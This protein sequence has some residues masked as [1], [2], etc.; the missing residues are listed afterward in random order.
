[1]EK[2]NRLMFI[3]VVL[4]CLAAPFVLSCIAGT[5]TAKDVQTEEQFWAAIK[6]N[7]PNSMFFV[8]YDKESGEPVEVIPS[9]GT[10]TIWNEPITK[11]EHLVEVLD[12]INQEFEKR[13][14]KK[15]KFLD[16]IQETS[17]YVH[18]S[19]GCRTKKTASGRTRV[20]CD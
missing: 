9:P 2:K 15:E 19:P 11:P 13:D 4:F 18:G 3:G 6:E 1:M 10:K 8:V 12:R 20:V 5:T 14:E 17:Y 16:T 7:L